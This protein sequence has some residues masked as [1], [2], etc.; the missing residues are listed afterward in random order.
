MLIL[1]DVIGLSAGEVAEALD[2]TPASVYS[3]L[4]RAHKGVDE[5]L[6]AQSQ[7]ATLRALGDDRLRILVESHVDAWER[8]DV[9]SLVSLLTDDVTLTMPPIPTWFHGR[10]AVGAFLAA[11]PL[12]H[13]QSWRMVP[14]R[15]SGQIAFGAY[16]RS[17]DRDVYSAH[18]IEVVTL[19]GDR[20]SELHAFMSP[21]SFAAFRLPPELH[22]LAMDLRPPPDLPLRRRRRQVEDGFM[23][24]SGRST[25]AA[26]GWVVALTGIGSLMAA[27]D[28]LVVSTALSTIR[29]D[30]HA[31]VEQL[32]G[33]STRTT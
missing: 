9:A 33:R 11:W 17:P 18:V 13:R 2:S 7:Q 27:L 32:D 1:R 16:S 20:I 14:V 3:A 30:L 8:G 21:E 10:E 23:G 4:Q 19:R 26:T 24:S 29:L 28:T 25:R 15:A 6:P 12:A 22:A 5:R 31:S